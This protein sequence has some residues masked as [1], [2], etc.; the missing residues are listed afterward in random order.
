MK[1]F[2]AAYQKTLNEYIEESARI[3]V[4]LKECSETKSDPGKDYWH[5]LK[6]LER[7][8]RLLKELAEGDD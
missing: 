5:K 4:L 1:E 8:L 3:C 2:Q 6:S 7:R